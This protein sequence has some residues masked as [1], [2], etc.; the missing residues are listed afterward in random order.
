MIRS[1]Q[2]TEAPGGIKI[3]K[4]RDEVF[5]FYAVKKAVARQQADG[6]LQPIAAASPKSSCWSRRWRPR[7][8]NRPA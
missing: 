5:A 2:I 8:T 7:P 4:Q 1:T 3:T 6:T